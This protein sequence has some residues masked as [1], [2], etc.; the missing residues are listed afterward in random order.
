MFKHFVVV[1]I[2]CVFLAGCGGSESSAPVDDP[3][4]TSSVDQDAASDPTESSAE[5]TVDD[6]ATAPEKSV[7]TAA[8]NGDV[9]ALK[10]HIA[11]GSDLN[12]REPTS[13]ATPLISAV[14]FDQQGAAR[15]LID[16][17]A[18]LSLKNNEGS[19]ALHI[20]AFLCRTEIVEMLLEAGAS[21]EAMNKVGATALNGVEG[22]FEQ[23]K[24]IYNL[25][26]ALLAPAGLELDYERIKATRPKI[27]EMLR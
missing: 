20:A 23:V 12:E 1:T 24:G 17:G 5:E 13:G 16:G 7:N 27:A 22:P 11:A 25:L 4:S 15:V 19:A 10:Q 18:D 26:R 6:S 21:K 9:E 3:N 2:S 14:T 8:F